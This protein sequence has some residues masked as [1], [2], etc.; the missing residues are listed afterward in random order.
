MLLYDA[1]HVTILRFMHLH[2]ASHLGTLDVPCVD[3]KHRMLESNQKTVLVDKP[4]RSC[5][6]GSIPKMEGPM[7]CMPRVDMFPKT[8][9][10][11]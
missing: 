7:E 5:V 9:Q 2:L 10:A 3:V 4:Q 11:N 1:S 6:G 8:A